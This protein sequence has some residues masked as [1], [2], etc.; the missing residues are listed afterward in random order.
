MMISLPPR[1][2]PYPRVDRH[3]L[4]QIAKAIQEAWKHLIG[5]S[6]PGG[7]PFTAADYVD[8]DKVTVHLEDILNRALAAG[9][10]GDWFTS[11]HFQTVVREGKITNYNSQNPDKMPDLVFRP[12]RMP[13]GVDQHY[14]IFIE[15]K[16]LGG[17]ANVG[18]YVKDGMRR[19]VIGDYAWC[20]PHSMML[21]YVSTGNSLP[22][23]LTSYFARPNLGAQ[24][25]MCTS[26]GPIAEAAA[27]APPQH[28]LPAVYAS[29]HGRTFTV[30]GAAPGDIEVFHMWLG[31]PP[32]PGG[33]PSPSGVSTG[34]T[35][36]PCAAT[37]AL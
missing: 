12:V 10:W 25:N 17:A 36:P 34:A 14:G 6:L 30:D 27:F 22:G 5:H 7:A 29:Q 19:F 1:V 24:A 13:R 35:N 31:T 28:G 15:C 3:V 21:A 37:P 9:S 18:D 32:P 16:V 33:T 8:E 23:G 26:K 2:L 20:M 11:R 4:V